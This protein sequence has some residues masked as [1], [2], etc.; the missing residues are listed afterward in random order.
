MGGVKN[1]NL[2]MH[3]A[4]V[5]AAMLIVIATWLG[6]S[7]IKTGLNADLE[8]SL[9][10]TLATSHKAAQ[11]FVQHEKSMA[12]LW[13]NNTM[14]KQT[15]NNLLRDKELSSSSSDVSLQVLMHNFINPI[16]DMLG[17]NEFLI[18][19][20]DG[21][22]IISNTK[23]N[24]DEFDFISKQKSLLNYAW[25]GETVFTF[26][27]GST[28]GQDNAPLINHED[29]DVLFVA[30]PI[31]ADD[32]H[33][34][35]ILVLR[36]D[37]HIEFFSIL[38]SARIG[39]TGE[40]YIFNSDGLMIS[41]SRFTD[42]LVS[43]GLLKRF[44]HAAMHISV[45]DPG[46]NL[47]KG[48]KPSLLR[49]DMPLTFMAREAVQGKPGVNLEGYRD[50][51]GVP[52]VGAWLWDDKLGF[53]IVREIDVS[54]AHFRYQQIRFVVLS[55]AVVVL[56]LLLFISINHAKKRK[57]V[58]GEKAYLSSLINNTAEGIITIDENGVI[59]T[60][61]PMVSSIFG[62][63][64]LDLMGKNISKLIAESAK[65]KYLDYFDKLKLDLQQNKNSSSESELCGQHKSGYNVPIELNI[66]SMRTSS[67]LKFVGIIRDISERKA[68]EAE[69]R[70]LLSAVEQSPAIVMITDTEGNIE[71]V[72]PRFTELSQYS[73]DEVVGRN[74]RVIKSGA[75]SKEN[76]QQMWQTLTSGKIWY[77]EFHNRRKDGSQYWVSA[78][79]APVMDQAGTIIHYV[80]VEDDITERKAAELALLEKQKLIELVHQVTSFANEA[81]NLDDALKIGLATI[82]EK[83]KWPI[84]HIYLRKKDDKQ[85][86]IP[87]NYWYLDPAGDFSEFVE[88]TRKSEFISGEGL[89]GRVL[90]AHKAVWIEDVS[91]DNYFLRRQCAINVGIHG[92]M[93]FPIM[94]GD[95]VFAVLEFF[96]PEKVDIS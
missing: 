39:P 95:N 25:S 73:V 91:N 56:L 93:A 67:E 51:R 60:I 82:C 55:F 87:S 88:V 26:L 38:E 86:L 81:T 96:T 37:P 40:T 84:G 85:K 50:Y 33:P 5:V 12:R 35:A 54:E 74:P 19:D 3:G 57:R 36:K 7:Q 71:Y 90:E 29:S 28:V 61:N 32:E 20:P 75:T 11:E 43:I 47:L 13:A 9:K 45:R 22:P 8:K 30:T 15:I 44:Q 2:Y 41:E 68:K 64:S 78:S 6:L 52:V 77:G 79:I 48:E 83:L 46:V 27:Q 70:K 72:N 34:M 62:Y 18:L 69:V 76:Y 31:L 42:Q 49:S 66:A 4:T 1:K 89:P 94:V 16:I 14:L 53:G 10:A 80:A 63:T 65:E 59:E 23:L 58:E 92:A 24:Q 17:Y 21:V